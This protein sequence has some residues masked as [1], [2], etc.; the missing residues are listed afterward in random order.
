MCLKKLKISHYMSTPGLSCNAMLKT[1]KTE[2]EPI[3]DPDMYIFFE[4]DQKRQNFLY[5]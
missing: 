5:F 2:L 3:S 1:K 4:K